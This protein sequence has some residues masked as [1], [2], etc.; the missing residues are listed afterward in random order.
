MRSDTTGRIGA[1]AAAALA[2]ALAG[3]PAIAAGPAPDADAGPGTVLG[4]WVGTYVCAQGLTGLTLSIAEAT[5]TS[6]R[7]L[8]HF[9]ADPRNPKV[10]TG[11]FAMDG[12][13]DPGSGRL[14][15]RGGEWRLRPGGYQVVN[16][17]GHV[18]AQGRRFSG[19]V[20]GA[21]ACKLFDLGRRPSPAPARAECAIAMPAAQPGLV[22]AGGIGAALAADGRIDLDILFDFGQAT[23]RADG[24]RQLDELG[25]SLQ[26][27]ALSQRRVGLHGHTDAVGGAD[28]NRALSE[29]RA[30]AVR[31]YLVARFAIRSGRLDVRGH[32]EDRLKRPDAPEDPANRRVEVLLL[33]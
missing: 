2:C 22:D 21:A 4:E 14:R 13:Y 9:Y 6:A 1:F 25:R 8:F 18:D 17:D 24:I 3:P 16:F 31:D 32:G 19:K 33:D 11:C 5:P 27:P 10:P 30:Q 12:D 23:L 28:A 29:R 15:L 7:A 26:S 20:G